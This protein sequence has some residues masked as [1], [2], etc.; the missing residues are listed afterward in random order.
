MIQKDS[1]K[2]QAEV[3]Q[4]EAVTAKKKANPIEFFITHLCRLS[5]PPSRSHSCILPAFFFFRIKLRLSVTSS[6]G[7]AITT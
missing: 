6:K 3:T 4:Q 5:L 2:S 7:K 1:H